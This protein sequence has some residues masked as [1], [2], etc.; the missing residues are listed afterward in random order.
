MLMFK[1]LEQKLP[2]SL[3]CSTHVGM[4]G[5][6]ERKSKR[7]EFNVVVHVHFMSGSVY[8]LLSARYNH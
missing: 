4:Y 3:K 2:L 1:Q 6:I 7:I 5:F 8:V